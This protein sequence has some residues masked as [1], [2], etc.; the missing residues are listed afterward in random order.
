MMQGEWLKTGDTYYR[1]AEAITGTAA[2]P[3]T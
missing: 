2:A 3:T 1:D